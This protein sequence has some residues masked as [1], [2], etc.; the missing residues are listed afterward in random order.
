MLSIKNLPDF[1]SINP[2]ILCGFGWA[3]DIQDRPAPEAPIWWLLP[4]WWSDGLLSSEAVLAVSLFSRAAMSISLGLTF[5][6]VATYA[7]TAP[8]LQNNRC[9]RRYFWKKIIYVFSWKNMPCLYHRNYTIFIICTHQAFYQGTLK[10]P[11]QQSKAFL[12]TG[13]PIASCCVIHFF[14][15]LKQ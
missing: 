13:I 11:A 3:S 6:P 10:G 4:V 14:L 1:L 12:V 15:I 2:N 9:Q 8:A 5:D 7:L